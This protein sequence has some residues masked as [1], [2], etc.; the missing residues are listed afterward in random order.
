VPI[1]FDRLNIVG[2]TIVF[3]VFAVTYAFG[4]AIVAIGGIVPVVSVILI[5]GTTT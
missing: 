1:Q 5:N 3:R 2:I 4:I